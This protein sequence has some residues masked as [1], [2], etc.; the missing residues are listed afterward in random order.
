MDK[1]LIARF[2]ERR[3][4]RFN[5][6]YSKLGIRLLCLYLIIQFLSLLLDP[7]VPLRSINILRLLSGFLESC[8]IQRFDDADP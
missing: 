7:V 5:H 3:L 4:V 2:T 1:L 8:N 6:G